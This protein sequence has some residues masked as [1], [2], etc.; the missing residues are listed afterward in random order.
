MNHLHEPPFLALAFSSVD[1]SK[2]FGVSVVWNASSLH[3]V[4]IQ[5]DV[6]Y[7][8][9]GEGAPRNDEGGELVAAKEERVLDADPSHPV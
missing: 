8:G 2:F 4:R 6:C 9:V 7:L 5:S 1:I 3:V